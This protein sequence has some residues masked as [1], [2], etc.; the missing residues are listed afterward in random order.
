MSYFG[1]P[2]CVINSQQQRTR[3]AYIR[4]AHSVKVDPTGTAG[5]VTYV[6][7]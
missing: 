1:D 2:G 5:N 4:D 6:H 7:K 3:V